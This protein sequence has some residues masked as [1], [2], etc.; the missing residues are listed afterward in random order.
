MLFPTLTV[1]C[2]MWIGGVHRSLHDVTRTALVREIAG[3]HAEKLPEDDARA[4][5]DRWIHRIAAHADDTP[6]GRYTA[7]RA[8]QLL[9]ATA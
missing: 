5:V 1:R 8:E 3:R 2:A 6:T 9:N 7:C 4:I